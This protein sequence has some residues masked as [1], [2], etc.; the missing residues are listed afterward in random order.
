MLSN[1]GAYGMTDLQK[2]FLGISPLG[3]AVVE[4]LPDQAK[5][6]RVLNRF[7]RSSE[8]PVSMIWPTVKEVEAWYSARGIKVKG[9]S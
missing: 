9:S 1:L 7:K 6:R 5:K 2:Q 4:A 3:A 8:C